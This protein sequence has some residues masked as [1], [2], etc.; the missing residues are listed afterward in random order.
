MT[1][2][3]DLRD[4]IERV[5]DILREFA[6]GGSGEPIAVTLPPIFAMKIPS[7]LFAV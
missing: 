1:E 7:C 3:P 2:K 5:R 6:D 4:R